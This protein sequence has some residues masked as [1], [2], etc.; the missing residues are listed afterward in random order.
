MVPYA[1]HLIMSHKDSFLVSHPTG[2]T[3][4]RGLLQELEKQG[5]LETFI[6]S[7]GVGNDANS[8]ARRLLGRR[9]Y[10][11]ASKQISS[12]WFPEI[13]RI[14]PWASK[15]QAKRR[16]QADYSYEL[17][18]K[19][20]SRILDQYAGSILHAYEDGAAHSFGQAKKHEI[21]CSYELPIA[22]WATVRK[23]LAEEAERLPDWEPTL[24]STREPEDKL[25][26]KEEELRLADCITCPSEF[27]LR[28]IPEDVR[29]GKPCLVAPF[30][31]PKSLPIKRNPCGDRDLKLLFVGS[32]SQRKGLADLMKAM[33]LIDSPSISLSILGQPSMPMS[34]Y[35]SNLS[36]FR[37]LSPRSNK[38]V[39]KVMQEHDVLVLPSIV[40][41]RALVQQEALACGL[42]LVVTENAGGED[43]IDEAE[44]G[45]LVPIRQPQAIAEKIEWFAANKK[46]LPEM[47]DFAQQKASLYRWKDY[48]MSIIGFCLRNKLPNTDN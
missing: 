8:L 13:L 17:I 15:S 18:D 2:N 1:D 28:S 48:A 16:R 11:V 14:N 29:E 5:L 10:P 46:L 34:F 47:S 35:R 37:Y 41:G 27:V 21:L 39:R 23:L 24:E 7:I 12:S 45:F 9:A 26:R 19:K 38:E 31:S 4:V 30:G 33:E 6:T 40:E 44:T 43:L 25:A 42:P 32:M 3:F 36:S 22:H 20:A